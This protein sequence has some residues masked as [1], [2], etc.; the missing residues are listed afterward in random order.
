MSSKI[1]LMKCQSLAAALL[2]LSCSI[3]T[4]AQK[5]DAGNPVKGFFARL[6]LGYAFPQA[7]MSQ[8][9]GQG[10]KGS[11]SL[12]GNTLVVSQKTVSFGQGPSLRVAGGYQFNKSIAAELGFHGVLSPEFNYTSVDG[13]LRNYEWKTKA[14]GPMY[15]VPAFVFSKGTEWRIYGRAGIAFPVT[16]KMT[17][18]LKQTSTTSGSVTEMTFE[19]EF[20]FKPGLEG[21]L[22][23]GHPLNQHLSIE[24]E[25][26][27]ISRNANVSRTELTKYTIDGLDG[28]PAFSTNQKVTEYSR[29]YEYTFP[30]SASEPAK[31]PTYAVPFSSFGV[32]V[33]VR[34][35][36]YP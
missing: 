10:I 28:L 7:G 22:G 13:S 34:W 29:D 25:L 17:Q 9:N 20:F 19:T 14:Q 35:N 18:D 30:P 15:V 21:S 16:N 11:E 26:S 32:N 36:F 33:G 5:N 31:A 6:A 4:S 12:N 27:L 3:A 24:A 1:A 23:V 2:V 8:I